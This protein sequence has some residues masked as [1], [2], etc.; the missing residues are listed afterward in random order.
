LVFTG[1]SYSADVLTQHKL[2][3]CGTYEEYR[4]ENTVQHSHVWTSDG[5]SSKASGKYCFAL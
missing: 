4:Q 3:E 5:S 1:V 2:T